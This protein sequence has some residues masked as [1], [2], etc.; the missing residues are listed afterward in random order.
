MLREG[1]GFAKPG[2]GGRPKGPAGMDD[3]A[4][5]MFMVE[6]CA[7]MLSRRA[8]QNHPAQLL[9]MLERQGDYMSWRVLD[10]KARMSSGDLDVTLDTLLADGA[11][12][13]DD[14]GIYVTPRGSEMRKRMAQDKIRHDADSVGCLSEEEKRQLEAL[15][16]KTMDHLRDLPAR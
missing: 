9:M 7:D 16:R 11:L 6:R 4:R 2:E 3:N 12:R 13:Q 14:W 5:L 1:L 8:S 15:L 10:E